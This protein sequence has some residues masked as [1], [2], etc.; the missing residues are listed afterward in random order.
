M[1]SS[2]SGSNSS[3]SGSTSSYTGSGSTSISGSSSSASSSS[4]GGVV[5]RTTVAELK[6]II[7]TNL[8][9]ESLQAYII[10]ANAFVTE[11]LGDDSTLSDSLKTEI[12]KWF[13]AHMIASSQERQAKKEG[14]GGAE[15]EYIGYYT[16]GLG[17]TSYGQMVLTL[18]TTGKIR[19]YT[20]KQPRIFAIPQFDE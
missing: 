6:L 14:A 10:G 16:A 18:D 15:I 9:D 20:G 11:V 13:A 5:T 3:Y 7:D 8:S 17:S 12:E 2:S 4:G 1:G 19:A